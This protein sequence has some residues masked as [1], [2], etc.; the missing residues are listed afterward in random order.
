MTELQLLRIRTIRELEV[1]ARELD[2][3]VILEIPEA[4]PTEPRA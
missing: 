4:E 2:P 3:N 1:A